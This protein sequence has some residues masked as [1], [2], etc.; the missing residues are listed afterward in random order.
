MRDG[1]QVASI[2]ERLARKRS[3]LGGV[4][5]TRKA[6]QLVDEASRENLSGLTDSYEGPADP[7]TVGSECLAWRAQAFRWATR[8]STVTLEPAVRRRRQ[9]ISD[10]RTADA[11]SSS[12]WRQTSIVRE[13]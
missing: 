8:P 4:A 9:T 12:C 13:L 3:R 11:P 7:R 10:I 6:A 5:F 1:R 2:L